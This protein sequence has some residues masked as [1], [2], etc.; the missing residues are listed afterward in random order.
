M[1]DP[2]NYR[3]NNMFYMDVAADTVSMSWVNLN[4]TTQFSKRSSTRDALNGYH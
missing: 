1:Y 3:K 2:V 4:A